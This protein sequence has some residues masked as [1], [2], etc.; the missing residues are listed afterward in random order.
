[1]EHPDVDSPNG[2]YDG[3]PE[4]YP[5]GDGAKSF[6]VPKLCNH[7]AHSPC[8]QVCPVD[9]DIRDGLQYECI[10]CGLCVDACNT[11]MDKMSYP[12]GLIRFTS[13]DE[14][15][16]G[17]THFLRPRLFG[18]VFAVVAMVGVFAYVVLTRSPI[19][20]DVIRDRGARLYRVVGNEIQNV[21]TVKIN[22]MDSRHHVYDIELQG[23]YPFSVKNYH[24]REVEAGE[25]FTLPVRVA[26]P[27]NK[28]RGEKNSLKFIVRARDDASM[29]AAED[30]VFMGPG[31]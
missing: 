13:E 15:R 12:R 20:V 31:R 5:T 16:T 23:D 7:C 19:G 21:Y 28:L 11:V 4:K 27:R 1:M 6:F 22:N 17:T 8:V 30:T 18:Y 14:L 9:I 29:V 3:F 2:G 10:N 26:V 24:P 25:V